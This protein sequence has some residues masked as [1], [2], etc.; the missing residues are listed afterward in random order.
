MYSKSSTALAMISILSILIVL[1]IAISNVEDAPIRKPFPG[2]EA[3]QQINAGNDFD[4]G[5]T[6]QIGEDTGARSDEA[7]DAEITVT[8]TPAGNLLQ[9]LDNFSNKLNPEN[10][11]GQNQKSGTTEEAVAASSAS[12]DKSNALLSR[13]ITNEVLNKAGYRDFVVKP[14][15]FDGMLFDRFDISML[16]YLDIVDKK[17]IQLQDGNEVEVLWAYEFNF[18]DGAGAQEIYDFLKAKLKDELGVT[19]NETNQFGLSSFYVNFQEQQEHAF[20]VV[21]TRTNVYALSYPKAKDGNV[22]YFVLTSN[23]LSELL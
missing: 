14:R 18:S 23:L 8:K 22:S 13:N 19:V 17:V 11:S 3:E 12:T 7:A 10:G 2:V 5:Q 15:P 9:T 6:G 21:K 20:L 1:F 4:S 16:S